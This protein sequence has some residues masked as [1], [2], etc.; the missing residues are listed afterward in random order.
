MLDE[1]NRYI[2][3]LHIFVL[4]AFAIA[5][6]VFDL[7]GHNTEFFVAHRAGPLLIFGMTLI[8]SLG[9]PLILCV[10]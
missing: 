2:M 4:E 8:L 6:P 9:I 1:M 10:V 7:L 5:Q 3:W